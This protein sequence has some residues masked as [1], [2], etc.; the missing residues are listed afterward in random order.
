MAGLAVFRARYT[1]ETSLAEH[2]RRIFPT[3]EIEI[4]WERGRF[5]C[6]IPRSL[7]PA[8]TEEIKSALGIDHYE[9]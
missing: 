7:A 2:L 8:E 4:R 1:D 5:Q 3:G 6:T 9:K